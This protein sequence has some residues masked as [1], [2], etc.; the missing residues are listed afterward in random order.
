MWAECRRRKMLYRYPCTERAGRK[1]Q[2]PDDC[3]YEETCT[4]DMTENACL[5]L[6]E[7]L[8]RRA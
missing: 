1:Y 4:P 8:N 3:V 6:M 2:T 5:A 7:E